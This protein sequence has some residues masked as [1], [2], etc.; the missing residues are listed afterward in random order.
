MG[1]CENRFD[2]EQV[3]ARP[4]GH[5][6]RK[7]FWVA[8]NDD[9]ADAAGRPCH[10]LPFISPVPKHLFGFKSWC[11][12]DEFCAAVAEFEEGGDWEVI[13]RAAGKLFRAGELLEMV[14]FLYPEE[15]SGDAIWLVEGKM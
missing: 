15:P 12:Q 4:A 9:G 10:G 2:F 11:G 14:R 3:I 1:K 8:L 5:K 13:E 7:L 6:R